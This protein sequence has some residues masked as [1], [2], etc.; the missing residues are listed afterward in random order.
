MKKFFSL[1]ILLT[2]FYGQSLY[3]QVSTGGIPVSWTND[4]L[5]ELNSAEVLP[6]VNVDLLKAE[7]EIER[8]HKDIP[9]RFA[10]GH[11]VEFS[12]STHGSWYV[13]NNGDRLWRLKIKSKNALTMSVTFSSFNLPEGSSVFIYAS[14]KTYSIGAFTAAN[15]KASGYLGTTPIPGEEIVVEYFEPYNALFEAELGIETVAH[16]YRDIFKIA[17]EQ[18]GDKGFGDSGDCN[19]N[20]VCPEAEDW[21]Q[22][23]KSVALITLSGGTRICTGSL[24][25][26]V[27]ED[28]TPYF[29]TANHCLGSSSDT[30]V[31]I[32]NYFSDI[33]DPGGSGND[34]STLESV[35]GSTLLENTNSN[36]G[37]ASTDPNETDMALLLLDEDIPESYDVFYNGWDWSGDIPANTVCIHHPSGDVKKITWDNDEPR[38][39]AILMK[40]Q[41]VI[42]VE[43]PIG[44]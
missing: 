7:D 17:A 9:M 4:I 43:P 1:L 30:W 29:L 15:N 40:A 8:E 42:W 22:Q 39:Q 12:S 41:M 23:I 16:G 24:L 20:V 26:N 28:E 19:N 10:Y 5:P 6:A 21:E 34:G 38:L 3:A 33:C 14:D 37:S 11:E 31:F 27:A 18:L 44:G 13:F 25:N 36:G 32:F 35:A 2:V